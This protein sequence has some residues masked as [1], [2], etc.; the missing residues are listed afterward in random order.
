MSSI[1]IRRTGA[2]RSTYTK[3]PTC[4]TIRDL[5]IES[6]SETDTM[7]GI[8]RF[9]DIKTND[10]L[11]RRGSPIGEFGDEE[12]ISDYYVPSEKEENDG[13]TVISIPNSI[14]NKIITP[15]KTVKSDY[16]EIFQVYGSEKAIQNVTELINQIPE[17]IIEGNDVKRTISHIAQNVL[18]FF[19]TSQEEIEIMKIEGDK[20]IVL[21]PFSDRSIGKELPKNVHKTTIHERHLYNVVHLSM[22]IKRLFEILDGVYMKE[23]GGLKDGTSSGK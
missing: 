9:S 15:I 14:I 2:I 17:L 16:K 12:N 13:C 11:Y 8:R 18:N 7:Q 22:D 23:Y 10:L 5:I 1:G 6:F 20:H 19:G 3:N 21:F 4:E